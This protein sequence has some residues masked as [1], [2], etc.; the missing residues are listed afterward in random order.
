M[1]HHCPWVNNCV[2]LYT[3]KPF[4]LFLIYSLIALTYAFSLTISFLITSIPNKASLSS[5]TLA[6]VFQAA[7]V[8]EALPFSLF[9]LTV[10]MDQ[11]VI[12]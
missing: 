8:C 10:L 3:Q 9:L 11:I 2:G 1:D 12:V 5:V 4:I 7:L 6:N